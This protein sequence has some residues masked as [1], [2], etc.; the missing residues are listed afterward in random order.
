MPPACAS[1]YLFELYNNHLMP[2]GR[3]VTWVTAPADRLRVLAVR[4]AAD[5]LGQVAVSIAFYRLLRLM[6]PAGWALLVP[7]CLFLFNPLTLEVSAWWAVGI[8]LLPMQLAMVLAVGAQVRYLRTGARRHLVTLALCGRRSACCSSRRRCSSCALVFLVTLCLYAPGG[9]VRAVLTDDPALVAGLGG[10]DRRLAAS[11]SPPTCRCRRLD[12]C[13]GRRRRGEV[14]T[15]LRQFFGAVARRRAGRRAVDLAGRR[16]R[17]RRSPRPTRAGA[18]GLLGA[19]RG[20]RRGARSGCAVAVAVRAW[21]LL[22]LYSALAAGLI[23]ATRLGSG[24][25]GVAGAGAAVPRRR[26][27]GRGD[28]RGRRAVRAAPTGRRCAPDPPTCRRRCGR[29]GGRTPRSRPLPL[30]LVASSVY[31]GV[32]FGS[33]WA[34]KAGPRLPAHRAA[35]TWPPPQ[36]G[37]VFMDQPVP[38]AVVARL[39]APVEHA[40][41]VLRP[42]RPTGR[43]SSPRPATLSVFDEAGHVRPAWVK[44]V[45]G[46]ARA[47]CRAAAT[48]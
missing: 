29:A 12:R 8:N 46:P 18:V 25:S 20:A 3:L 5:L 11:T 35:P 17:R 36:P 13:A 38:E 22:A 31:S 43:C 15:F 6:L 4:H 32:G 2:A 24:F 48:R 42:A 34:V 45:H 16:G 47:G 27:A 23:G 7:L 44:G 19:G 39:S 21:I 26:A 33:D 41:A 30:L 10:A 14:G 37:T 40:V 9:P 28:L 1:D